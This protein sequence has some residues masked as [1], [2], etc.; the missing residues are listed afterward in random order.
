MEL[1]TYKPIDGCKEFTGTLKAFDKETV[2]IDI[3]GTERDFARSDLAKIN[4]YV[5]L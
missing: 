3:E 2:H 1:K 5:D 4:L